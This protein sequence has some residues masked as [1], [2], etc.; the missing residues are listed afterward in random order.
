[1]MRNS[2]I[3]LL[4]GL[5]LAACAGTEQRFSVPP[6]SVEDERIGISYPTVE[7]VEVSLPTYAGAEEI[8]IRGEGGALESSGELLWADKPSR[9]ITLELS[10]HIAQLTGARV[11]PEPWPFADR[12]TARV[13]VRVEEM[14]AEGETRFVMS[15]QYFVAPE[16]GGRNRSGLFSLSAP[17]AEGGGAAAIAAARGVVVRDL[18]REIARK[19]LR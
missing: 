18:A 2:L 17:I 6:A 19:G 7:I 12:A 1:M 3:I 15:G 14:L 4:A 11:A 10:R 5:A 8:S 13:D 9:A 16:A